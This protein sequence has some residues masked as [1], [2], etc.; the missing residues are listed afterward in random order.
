MK[1]PLCHHGVLKR[2][3][4]FYLS[5]ALACAWQ[6][7]AFQAPSPKG[8]SVDEILRLYVAAV[9]GEDAVAR[10]KT[11]ES[12]AAEGRTKARLSWDA[13]DRVLWILGPEREGFDG[14]TGWHETKRKRVQKLPGARK[15][16]LETDANPI[17]F[18]HLKDMY[19]DLESAP[20]AS[21]DGENADVIRAPNNL[22]ATQFFFDAKTHLLIRIEEFGVQSAYYKHTIEFSRY[23]DFDGVKLPTLMVRSSDEPGSEEGKL[24]LA[25][26][27]QNE[28]LDPEIFRKPDI[29]KVISGGKH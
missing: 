27:R 29:G 18:V 25:K 24:R 1:S 15:D 14:N 3:L 26:I 7:P 8:K 17:R 28:P 16:E 22:G 2:T 23:E 20:P 21:V 19:R 4:S 12:L 11:R 6:T 9:G 13:P 10:V 5:L